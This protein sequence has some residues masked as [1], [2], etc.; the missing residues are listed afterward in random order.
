MSEDEAISDFGI[1]S[2]P[3][4]RKAIIDAIETEMILEEQEEGDQMLLKCLCIQLFSIGCVEDCLVVWRVKSHCFDLML[5]VDVQLLCGAGLETTR[6]FLTTSLDPTATEAL[7]Y[8]NECVETG[9]FQGWTPANT[10]A[11]YRRYYH[12]SA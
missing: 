7:S 4:H 9:D 6:S 2:S 10:V 8:L 11:D 1:P 3:D 12:L 5:G